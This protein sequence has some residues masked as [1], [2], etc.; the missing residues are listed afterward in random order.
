MDWFAALDQY[1]ER[2]GPNFWS[3]PLNAITNAAFIIAGLI[4]WHRVGPRPLGRIMAAEVVVIGVGSFLFHTF[5][6]RWAELADVLPILIFILTYV[7]ASSRD[8]LG[9]RPGWALLTA[10]LYIPYSALTVPLFALIPGLGSSVG[11]MPVPLLILGYAWLVRHRAPAT[12]RGL[13]IGAGILALSLTFRTLDAPF[14]DTWPG[15]TH[16]V[17]HMLNGLMLGWMIEVWRRHVLR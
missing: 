3:E 2:T 15:G 14:C 16:F 11:Y 10:A 7:F 9:L 4:L 6:T 5:A 13:V 1:C 8:Y 12:A 17:W